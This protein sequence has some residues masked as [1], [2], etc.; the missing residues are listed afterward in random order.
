VLVN[1]Y[2]NV[3]SDCQGKEERDACY[4]PIKEALVKHFE[5]IPEDER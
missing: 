2:A 5:D 3:R 4:E 1:V